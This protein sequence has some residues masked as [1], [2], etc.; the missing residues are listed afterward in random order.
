VE[1]QV[2]DGA[3]GMAEGRGKDDATCKSLF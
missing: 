2:E 1:A 3:A